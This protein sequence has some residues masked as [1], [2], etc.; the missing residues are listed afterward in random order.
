[1]QFYICQVVLHKI[2]CHQLFI[3]IL[4]SVLFCAFMSLPSVSTVGRSKTQNSET[5]HCSHQRW[6]WPDLTREGNKRVRWIRHLE[7]PLTNSYFQKTRCNSGRFYV[8]LSEDFCAQKILSLNCMQMIR[9]L[10][11]WFL[12][13]ISVV[14]TIRMHFRNLKCRDKTVWMLNCYRNF[15]VWTASR[16]TIGFLTLR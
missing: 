6:L 13:F 11:V 4:L 2:L 8:A 12:Q 3:Y 5:P 1:M 16:E 7:K 14:T 15:K 10:F 9:E